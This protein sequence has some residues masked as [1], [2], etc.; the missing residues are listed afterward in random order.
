MRCFFL[1]VAL[2]A[3]CRE[4]MAL[5][6]KCGCFL[7]WKITSLLGFNPWHQV[8]GF[9]SLN[10]LLSAWLFPG[11]CPGTLSEGEIIR[12]KCLTGMRSTGSLP[13]G[14]NHECSNKSLTRQSTMCLLVYVNYRQCSRLLK[15]AH[16]KDRGMSAHFPFFS[17][18]PSVDLRFMSRD[19]TV[20]P[21]SLLGA[22]L[23]LLWREESHCILGSLMI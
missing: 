19:P 11:Q 14:D 6:K 16:G 3:T 18:R 2:E 9:S 4:E 8:L 5:I 23:I 15:C 21:E 13:D 10:R 22:S 1:A 20:A 17:G 7:Q 12:K